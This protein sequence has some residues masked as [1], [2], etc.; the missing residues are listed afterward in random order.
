MTDQTAP[1]TD[2]DLDEIASRAA[3]LYEYVAVTVADAEPDFEQLTD[4][5]VPAL[6]AEV[7]RL[8]AVLAAEQSAHR[9]TLRQR[10]NRSN[11]LIHLRDLALARDTE[12]LL[13]AAKD[14][15]AASVDDHTGCSD[16]TDETDDEGLSGPCDCGEGAVHYTTADC[17]A[18][19]RA[20]TPAAEACGKCKTVFDPA[21]TRFDGHAQ[22]KGTPYCRRCVDLCRD[23]EIADH[24]C[25]ICA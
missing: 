18:A 23:N 12:A 9:F 11:R 22:H 13:A 2:L 24:R 5:D 4:T 17:P 7:R 16:T 8:R 21:D 15:L 14:T 1:L 3:H 20:A 6:L 25:V 10:N 19:Q